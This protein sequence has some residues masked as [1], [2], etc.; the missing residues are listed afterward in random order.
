MRWGEGGRERG[1][2]RRE[3]GQ[4]GGREV[5]E[6]EREAGRR[7]ERR[8]M[9]TLNPSARFLTDRCLE[10]C[11]KL[12]ISSLLAADSQWTDGPDFIYSLHY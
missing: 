10:S 2:G 8:E 5:G 9:E 3:R 7:K 4:G 6:R 1:R 11:T 12:F